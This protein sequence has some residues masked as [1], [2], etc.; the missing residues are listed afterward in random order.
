MRLRR[1]AA[2]AALPAFVSIA[3]ASQGQAG[4]GTAI[5]SCNQT[6]T[7]NAYL[8]ASFACPG[9]NGV[10]VGADEITIDLRGFTLRGN[11][12]AG[13]YGIDDNGFDHV[14]IK[15]GV[16]RNFQ[17]GVYAHGTA[18]GIGISD[19]VAS[20]N[21]GGG[22]LVG[23][24]SASVRSSTASG[25]AGRGIDLAG[26]RHKIQS[27]AAVGN[28]DTGIVVEGDSASVK[29][30]TASG[31][32]GPGIQ[33][34][35]DSASIQ[36]A[37]ATGNGG[38]GIYASG[39]STE[40]RSSAASGNSFMGIEVYGAAQIKANRAEA[41]GFAGGMSDAVGLGIGQAFGALTGTNTA[42]GNDDGAECTPAP[43]C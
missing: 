32:G 22:I 7:T 25:N 16:V 6:V 36:G 33:V 27:S 9:T 10:V 17:Y 42:R 43:L 41:N 5:A 20:G 4:G 37:T 18:D 15:N 23:G 1:I 19:L 28:A 21:A 12:T 14:T 30:A 35:G 34:L 31:N 2:L 13:T 8:I 24:E 26:N 11:R 38:S 3:A 39:S 40:V 29:S